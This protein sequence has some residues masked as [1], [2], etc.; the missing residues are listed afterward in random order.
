MAFRAID[1]STINSGNPASFVNTASA[2][3]SAGSGGTSIDNVVVT[4]VLPEGLTYV[5]GSTSVN[6]G[7]CSS[8]DPASGIALATLRAGETAV[9]TFRARAD[10]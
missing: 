8:L 4:D 5:T 1:T 10:L 7:S 2:V 9:I 6:G 3:G